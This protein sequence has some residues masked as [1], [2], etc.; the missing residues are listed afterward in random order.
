MLAV[1]QHQHHRPRAQVGHQRRQRGPAGGL[2]AA[3]HRQGGARHQGPVGQRRQVHQPDAVRVRPTVRPAARRAGG[4]QQPGGDLQGQAGLAGAPGA[5]EGHQPGAGAGRRQA[6]SERGHLA[7]PADEA[8]A[9]ERQVGG[10]RPRPPP[11]RDADRPRRADEP[12][13]PRRAPDG[14]LRRGLEPGPR[15]PGEG[16]GLRQAARRRPPRPGLARLQPLDGAHPQPGPLGQRL[17]RQPGGQPLP[18]QHA[19]ERRGAGRR[20]VRERFLRLHPPRLSSGRRRRDAAGIE[21]RTSGAPRLPAPSRVVGTPR[22][23]PVLPI[24]RRRVGRRDGEGEG[25]GARGRGRPADLPAP[26]AFRGLFRGSAWSRRA[27]RRR[28]DPAGPAG[29]A[30][31]R[32]ATGGRDDGAARK[33][34]RRGT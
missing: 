3:H 21:Y 15:R 11:R 10:A 14:G 16:Q 26:A 24:E 32:A 5:G 7:L 28:L 29:P 34:A 18:P 23:L 8:G 33:R 25:D 6:A 2:A 12:Q 19:A 22:V 1:V 27:R 30:P 13:A 31:G 17:L 4:V 20:R 9:R